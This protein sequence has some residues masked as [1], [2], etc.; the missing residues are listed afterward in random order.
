MFGFEVM[1][2]YMRRMRG[3]AMVRLVSRIEPPIPM[4]LATVAIGC[5]HPLH[6][7]LSD[8]GSLG[9]LG[10]ASHFGKCPLRKNELETYHLEAIFNTFVWVILYFFVGYGI[11]T[12]LAPSQA[13]Q[14]PKQLITNLSFLTTCCP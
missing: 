10:S 12:P 9:W 8:G 7:A 4:I 5:I 14:L 11:I 6:V 3:R 13:D 1:Q 2:S